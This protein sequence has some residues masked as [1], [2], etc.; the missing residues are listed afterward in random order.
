MPSDLTV[1]AHGDGA[2]RVLTPHAAPLARAVR[3]APFPGF[4]EAIPALGVLLVT[5]DP[6]VTTLPTVREALNA[7]AAALPP[8]ADPTAARTVVLPV[9]YDGPD[10]GWVAEHARLSVP[11]VIA[12]HTGATY[13]VAFL[14]FTPGFVFLT[15]TPPELQMPR[16]PAPRTVVPAGSVALGGPWAGVYPLAAPGGWRLIGRTAARLFDP[17]REPPTLL[18]DGDTVRFEVQG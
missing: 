17:H 8:E 4:E 10:L 13:R 2:A 18:R 9:V 1:T 12:R 7:H 11:E 14:G 3:A 5:F 6:L 15:G 16:L